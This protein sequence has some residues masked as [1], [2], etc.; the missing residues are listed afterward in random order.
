MR[1][2]SFLNG[3]KAQGT[4][5]GEAKVVFYGAGSSAV[6]VASMIARLIELDAKVSAEDARK[7]LIRSVVTACHMPSLFHSGLQELEMASVNAHAITGN[8]KIKI[9]AK[10]A[11]MVLM[12]KACDSS[13]PLSSSLFTWAQQT[14]ADQMHPTMYEFH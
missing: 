7:V 8:C 11:R 9:S 3:M 2:R 10:D 5:L 14:A 13:S 1:L 6:G 4:P 12:Y